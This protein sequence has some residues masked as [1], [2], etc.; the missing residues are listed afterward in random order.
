MPND[1]P[2]KHSLNS[3][4]SSSKVSPGRSRGTVGGPGSPFKSPKGK[5]SVEASL[6]R[7]GKGKG[8]RGLSEATGM[9][10]T[11]RRHG[12]GP[13]SGPGH[14]LG[15]AHESG[16]TIIQDNIPTQEDE[17]VEMMDI[18]DPA[19]DL[20]NDLSA[21]ESINEMLG[22]PTEK[23]ITTGSRMGQTQG[24]KKKRSLLGFAV[25]GGSKVPF[26]AGGDEEASV[27]RKS[28][29]WVRASMEHF[30]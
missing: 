17:D 15:G 30:T 19:L 10:V 9:P 16:T 25:R 8:G 26:V 6:K 21:L 18:P 14:S 22:L 27:G 3:S 24:P 1:T 12:P 13:S 11:P 7:M 5:S 4:H 28:G 2:G 29:G 20:Q 23:N